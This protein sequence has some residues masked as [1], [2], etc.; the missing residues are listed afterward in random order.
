MNYEDRVTKQYIEDAIA[1][2]GVKFAMGSYVGTGTYGSSNRTSITFDF[3]PKVV[4]LCGNCATYKFQSFLWFPGV[5]TVQAYGTDLGT[6]IHL[7]GKTLTWFSNT[8]AAA[9]YNTNDH[10]Y[11]WL[12]IG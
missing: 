4:M 11:Y 12:A 6:P 1:N 5:I 2:A 8:S 3:V 7:E 9:Q 10:P